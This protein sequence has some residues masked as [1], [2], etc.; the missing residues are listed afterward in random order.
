M[1]IVETVLFKTSV[2]QFA[3]CAEPAML[4]S[5]LGGKSVSIFTDSEF[6]IAK[7]VDQRR[8]LQNSKG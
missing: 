7:C 4:F 3:R 2:S 5:L 1:A 6:T 8:V